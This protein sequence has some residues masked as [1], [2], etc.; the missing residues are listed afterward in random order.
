V[1]YGRHPAVYAVK[2]RSYE[3]W[4]HINFACVCL[5]VETPVLIALG[6]ALTDLS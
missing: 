2:S 6:R 4:P 5:S 3:R 1:R